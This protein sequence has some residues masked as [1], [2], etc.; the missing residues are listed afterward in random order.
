M[1]WEFICIFFLTGPFPVSYLHWRIQFSD[2][3]K[4][5]WRLPN[6]PDLHGSFLCYNYKLSRISDANRDV[7]IVEND[8]IE[9]MEKIYSTA[10]LQACTLYRFEVQVVTRNEGNR[11][12]SDWEGVEALTPIRGKILSFY[13][14]LHEA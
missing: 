3:L 14:V 7:E 13:R 2:Q 9:E 6:C 1:Q 11:R 10:T 4:F 12:I 8:R 5:F